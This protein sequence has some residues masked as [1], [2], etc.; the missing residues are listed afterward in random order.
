MRNLKICSVAAALALCGCSSEVKNTNDAPGSNTPASSASSAAGEGTTPQTSSSATS[1]SSDEVNSK[2][3]PFGSTFTWD[4]GVAIT[5]SKPQ[6]FQPS[7]YAASDTKFK[8]FVIVD[9]TLKNGS[10]EPYNAM[11]LTTTAT[12]GDKQS[13]GAFDTEK[14]VDLPTADIL[15]GKTLTWKQAYGVDATGD[16]VIAV[17]NGFG[18]AKGYYK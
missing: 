8:K 4:D 13:D 9:V 15:P 10:K 11:T 2:T 18:N 12:S 7:P 6:P 16:L 14:G 5:I 17:E 3:K 1:T